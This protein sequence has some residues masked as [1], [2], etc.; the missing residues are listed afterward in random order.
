V[1]NWRSGVLV[2]TM[3]L[4]LAACGQAGGGAESASRPSASAPSVPP[5]TGTLLQTCPQVQKVII[6]LGAAPAAPVLKVASRQVELL[7]RAGNVET[8]KALG[9][10][11][12]ALSAYRDAHAG[13]QTLDAKSALA[14]SLSS[15]AGRCEV[16]G[17]FAPQ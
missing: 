16:V 6:A 4:G 8:Q 1:K 7:Y 13:Q 10:L 14:G 17:G 3:C 11:V 9:G 15:F 12:T 2:V 5:G